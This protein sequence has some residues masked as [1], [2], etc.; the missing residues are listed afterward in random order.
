MPRVTRVAETHDSVSY[1]TAP[2]H[3]TVGVLIT[4]SADLDRGVDS[5]GGASV[6]SEFHLRLKIINIG[7]LGTERAKKVTCR[8]IKH[9]A[10]V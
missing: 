1:L 3:C 9:L 6:G 7:R 5:D 4:R 8:E 10:D 2:G